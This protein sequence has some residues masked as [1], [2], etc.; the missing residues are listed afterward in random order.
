MPFHRPPHIPADRI[1]P[2]KT[3]S[4]HPLQGREY[5]LKTAGRWAKVKIEHIGE[6]LPDGAVLPNELTGS[7]RAEIAA[8]DE[9]D[10]MERQAKIRGKDFD[11]AAWYAEHKAEAEAKYA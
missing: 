4:P 5:H 11:A 1:I 2:G 7:Q 9:A 3:R 10:R 8:Q 6:A